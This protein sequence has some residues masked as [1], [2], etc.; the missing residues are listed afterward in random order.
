[1]IARKQKLI[2][3]KTSAWVIGH[4]ILKVFKQFSCFLSYKAFQL[5]WKV[6]LAQQHDTDDNFE[7]VALCAIVKLQPVDHEYCVI[8]N[9]LGSCLISQNILTQ[10]G[11]FVIS[12]ARNLKRKRILF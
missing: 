2:K 6:K 9:S 3:S 11:E 7:A 1:M 4:Q 8:K 5:H 10:I 12:T